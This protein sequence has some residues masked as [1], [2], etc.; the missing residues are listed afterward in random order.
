MRAMRTR[1]QW[2][3]V[4]DAIRARAKDQ[5]TL[6]AAI[7]KEAGEPRSR[8]PLEVLRDRNPVDFLSQRAEA[9]TQLLTPSPTARR[10]SRPPMR[11]G[12]FIRPLRL[13]RNGGWLILR[14][15]Y[16]GR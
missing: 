7:Q 4:E 15:L 5:Q 16:C 10:A 2:P 12:R 1:S 11:G 6:I 9:L 3:A 14:S 13:T 8:S